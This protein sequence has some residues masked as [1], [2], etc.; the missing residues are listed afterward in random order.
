MRIPSDGWPEKT[1]PATRLL[2]APTRRYMPAKVLG[3][4]AV[5]AAF[6]PTQFPCTVLPVEVG[7]LIQMPKLIFPEM[8]FRA[9][10]F[11]PPTRLLNELL[12]RITPPN[13][14]E[15]AFVPETSV[16]T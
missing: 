1:L 16:P 6:R 5:P 4:A 9:S 7:P 13:E 14:L 2:F 15:I 3:N 8:I 12:R 11:V 10:A